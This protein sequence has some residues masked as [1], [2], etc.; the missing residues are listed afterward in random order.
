MFVKL[1]SSRQT[2]IVGGVYRHPGGDVS[3]FSQALEKSLN[4]LD[5]EETCILAG[6]YNINLLNTSGS[7][8]TEYLTTLLSQ[9]FLPYITRP[10]RITEYTAI[11]IDHFFV[12]IPTKSLEMP[13]NSGILFNDITDH[14]PIFLIMRSRNKSVSRKQEFGR[15]Y[16]N[17]NIQKFVDLLAPIKW[18]EILNFDDVDTQYERFYNIL[19]TSFNQAFPLVKISRARIKDKP[20]IT[21]GLRKSIRKKNMLYRKSITRPS[22]INTLSYKKYKLILDKCLRYAEKSH[23]ARIFEDKRNSAKNLWKRFGPILNAKSKRPRGIPMLKIDGHMVGDSKIIAES[24]NEFFCDM[25]A[26]LDAEI[27]VGENH[28]RQYLKNKVLNSFFINPVCESDVKEELLKLN[29]RK[30]SGPDNYSPKIVRASSAVVIRPLTLLYNA[31]IRG[32]YYPTV[33]KTAKVIPLYKQALKDIVDNY[34]PINLLNC[35][36]KI[37]EKLIHKQLIS[38]LNKHMLLFQYQYGFRESHSTTLALI[39]IIDDIK[40]KLNNGEYVIGAYLDLKKAFDTVNHDILCDKLDHYGIR[41]HSLEFFK[42]YLTNRRQF[43]YCNNV[44]SSSREITWSTPR[45]N[46]GPIAIFNLYK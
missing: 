44:S 14:L 5:K 30:A 20:W 33:L 1:R 38:F 31:S 46:L 18:E 29:P 41:G 11:L 10:T 3:H 36:N 28:F 40:S 45:L 21:A 8:T 13:I 17:N 9:G 32:A 25:G 6:D 24:F 19:G 39:E 27:P 22:E 12:K 42:S 15:I 37:F 7:M 26:K 43:T 35:F 16:N 23:L 34:R 4:M 2:Y